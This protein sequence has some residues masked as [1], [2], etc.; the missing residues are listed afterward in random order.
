MSEPPR[1][2]RS[3]RT[4]DQEWADLDVGEYPHRL[5]VRGAPTSLTWPDLCANCASAA[6]ERIRV[7][8]A[9]FRRGRRKSYGTFGYK[10]VSANIPFCG[11]C[12][13]RHR[14]TVENVSWFKR[15]GWWLLNPAHIATIGFAVMLALFLPS[16]RETPIDS[17]G[18]KVAWGIAAAFAFGIVWTIAV[19]WWMTRPD[20]FEPRSDITSAC[21][22]S[23]DVAQ[24]LEG[25][26]HIYGFRNE[27]FAQAFERAN[28]ERIWTE[29]DQ[30][31]MWKKSLVV[32]IL[33]IAAIGGARLL[34]WVYQGK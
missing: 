15:Y 18:G 21:L 12:A 29:R 25:R 9:F 20:R 31:W 10:V 34:L 30:A 4:R 14:Q 27:T 22:V 32:T 11:S 17:E 13:A 6:S 33:L 28:Q 5:E 16:V 7:R 1:G 24:L 23:H 8:R 19:T 2:R 26:R 3:E